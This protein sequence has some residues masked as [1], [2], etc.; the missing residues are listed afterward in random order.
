[1][2]PRTSAPMGP[3]KP[4]AGV[5]ATRP[6]M[7]PEAMPR[8]LGLPFMSHSM[9]IQPSAAVAVAMKVLVIAMTAPPAASRFEPALKPNQPNHRSMAPVKVS[10]S[11][12]GGIRSLPC[13]TRFPTMIGKRVGH[14]K[15]LMPPH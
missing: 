15:D 8:R 13:P 3:A 9:V 7:A 4:D 11:E 1:M 12:G 5:T 10:G 2:K 14:G 6:A